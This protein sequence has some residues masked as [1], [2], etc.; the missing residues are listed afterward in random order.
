M[1][2]ILTILPILRWHFIFVVEVMFINLITILKILKDGLRALTFSLSVTNYS[3]Y[4]QRQLKL[5][6]NS[7]LLKTFLKA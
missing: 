6:S 5:N 4:D 3:L 2:E 7:I 1:F